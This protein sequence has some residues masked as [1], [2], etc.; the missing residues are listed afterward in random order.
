MRNN[1]ARGR[2]N[3]EIAE[4]GEVAERKPRFPLFVHWPALAV[5]RASRFVIA[6]TQCVAIS[7]RT[8]NLR[9]PRDCFAYA[10]AMTTDRT[11]LSCNVN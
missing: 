2:S 10:L 4:G 3:R 9:A 7:W 8:K 1:E 6:S 11:R 5:R